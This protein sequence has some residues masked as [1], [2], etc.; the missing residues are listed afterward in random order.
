MIIKASSAL[1]NDFLAIDE[2]A[3]NTQEPIFITKNGE[4]SGV[5]LSLKAYEKREAILKLKEKLLKGEEERLKGEYLSIEDAQ[6]QL[7]ERLNGI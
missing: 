1:R 6:R 2:L 7:E 4:G 3:Y 5:Y